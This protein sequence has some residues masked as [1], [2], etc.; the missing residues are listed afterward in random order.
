MKI[1]LTGST[2]QL[3]REIIKNKPNGFELIEAPRSILDLSDPVS[4][5][6]FILNNK[7]DYLINCAAY[8]NVE[9]AESEKELAYLINTKS[10]KYLAESTRKI[11]GTFIQLSTDYVFDGSKKLPYLPFDSKSPLNIYG[12]T[13][14]N[15]EDLIIDIFKDTG[16]GKIIRTSW[17]MGPIGNNFALKMLGL[18]SE[19]KKIS[20]INDQMGA[21]TTTK[22]LALAC[23]KTINVISSGVILPSILHY[24]N[25]GE[26]S[27]YE[28][29]IEILKIGKKLQ[30]LESI[31]E[32][33][34]V[35]S[36]EFP[37]NALRPKYSV[38]DSNK[39]LESISFES[40]HWVDAIESLFYEYKNNLI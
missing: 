28:I 23:W 35:T 3:G 27:W 18:L 16:K 39:S 29:A 31:P 10:V 19:K 5:G 2:G 12:K 7:P 34:P 25:Q 17:L 33:S 30:L 36:M 14:S 9:K 15:A 38:L 20:V 6:N 11:N 21:P 32:I 40:Q 4:C 24:T 22:T 1:I 37:T 26:A 13:K 8:T